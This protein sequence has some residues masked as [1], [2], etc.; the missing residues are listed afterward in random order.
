MTL[1]QDRVEFDS[2]MD[3][4]GGDPIA[5]QASSA[6]SCQVG[7]DRKEGFKTQSAEEGNQPLMGMMNTDLGR[8]Y[9]VDGR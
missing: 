2:M 5:I 6:L 9:S 1:R 8:P 7:S 3:K 4:L